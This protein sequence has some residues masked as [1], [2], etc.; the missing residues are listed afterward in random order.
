MEPRFGNEKPTPPELGLAIASIAIGALTSICAIPAGIMLY[1]LEGIAVALIAI[2]PFAVLATVLGHIGKRSPLGVAGMTLGIVALVETGAVLAVL[3]YREARRVG[4][5]L[6]EKEKQ[7]QIE[8]EQTRQERE[9]THQ[10]EQQRIRAEETAKIAVAQAQ[11]KQAILEISKQETEAARQRIE[12]E[13]KTAETPLR[14]LQE[15]TKIEDSRRLTEETARAKADAETQVNVVKKEAAIAETDRLKFATSLKE[16]GRTR[17]NREIENEY[18]RA[19]DEFYRVRNLA[20]EAEEKISKLEADIITT[21]R[22]ISTFNDRREAIYKSYKHTGS[23]YFAEQEQKLDAIRQDERRVHERLQQLRE[24]L[25]NEKFGYS[26]RMKGV[27]S[28]SGSTRIVRRN[29]EKAQIEL[30][31]ARAAFIA[32]GGKPEEI[33]AQTQQPKQPTTG[34][35]A[36][37]GTT[38]I[39][40]K[41]G[42]EFEASLFMEIGIEYHCKDV[43]G[44][45][46]I[47]KKEEVA[48]IIRPDKAR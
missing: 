28:P 40:L 31:T 7:H 30:E 43:Q 13:Q 44:K 48:E 15:Q 21:E 23:A 38:T 9:R 12:A 36:H 22:M 25:S 24:Q 39:R 20:K 47:L 29:L 35:S 32:I 41:D 14:I 5:I 37:S 33:S 17:S 2:A 45:M 8:Q 3:E 27:Y 1:N 46:R 10:A 26:Y 4:A 11:E 34:A 19:L 18:R 6:A 16:E 42:S